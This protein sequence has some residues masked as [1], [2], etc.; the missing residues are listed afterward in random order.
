MKNLNSSSVQSNI[1]SK[2]IW[3]LGNC[4]V[5]SYTQGDSDSLPTQKA[6][7]EK[8]ALELGVHIPTAAEIGRKDGGWWIGV[9]SSKKG[10]NVDRA[11]LLEMVEVCKKYK[12]KIRYI[13]LNEADRFMRSM[14]EAGYFITEFAKQG[15]EI[16][17]AKN[18]ELNY[19]ESQ[20]ETQ[21][22]LVDL[23]RFMQFFGAQSSN[24]ERFNK[25]V[26]GQTSAIKSGRYPFVPK[27]GYMKGAEAGV[28]VPIPE[29]KPYLKSILSRLGDGLI[30]LH[31]SMEEYNNCPYVKSGKQKGY[32]FDRWK[33][34]VS[35]PYYAGIVEKN[36]KFIKA[37]CENGRH[38]ALITKEQHLYIVELVNGKKKHCNGPRKN[39]NPDFLL[40]IMT[41][42]KECH[43]KEAK[44]GRTGKSDRGKLVGYSTT[45]GVS[46]KKYSRY[47]CRKAK[48]KFS[49]SKEELE[50]KVKD[51]LD[52]LEFT[53]EH[54]GEVEKTLK[55]IWKIEEDNDESEIKSLRS[56]LAIAEK[57]FNK[58]AD[59][60]I[61]A[62]STNATVEKML[63]ERLEKADKE[64]KEYKA[65][66]A[67]LL[68]KDNSKYQEFVGFAIHFVNHLGTHFFKLTPE[69]ARKCELLVFPCGILVDDNKKVQ[70][71][72][73]SWFYRGRD[74]K[75]ESQDSDL[76]SMVECTRLKLVTS[77]LPAK[78]SIS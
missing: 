56:K 1:N 70:I 72:E 55:R 30:T 33:K 14:N 71:P 13:I 69:Y 41:L 29:L 40:N 63:Q 64:I 8:K 31:Q 10:K 49:I 65:R 61:S 54:S 46:P 47:K 73:I 5:S 59:K 28:H 60:L 4:R 67:E 68:D 48:C 42:H 16:V 39:G 21:K 26:N 20:T 35:D 36:G 25:A 6:N 12:G 38:E 43:E 44:E 2:K 74:N 62:E 37:R 7:I 51:I 78:R 57:E 76:P 32:Q 18:P 50:K 17:F 23:Q 24:T 66:I 22:N 19:D 77:S 75:K 9:H 53:V 27:F 45:N 34:V 3:A 11:D 15:V 52:S 58:I